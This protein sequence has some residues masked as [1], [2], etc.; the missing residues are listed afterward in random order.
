MMGVLQL[1]K[2]NYT[3]REDD[4]VTK[5]VRSSNSITDDGRS[6]IYCPEWRDKDTGYAGPF[7]AV[8]QQVCY[9]AYDDFNE[10]LDALLDQIGTPLFKVGDSLKVKPYTRYGKGGSVS[11]SD[12]M[13]YVE[14]K[15]DYKTAKEQYNSILFLYNKEE[16]EKILMFYAEPIN[17][18]FHE[19]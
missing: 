16:G 15:T 19:I 7:L 14:I 9:G 17:R 8:H 18:N 6:F 3:C 10:A 2:I 12:R 5:I 13:K 11:D 1:A 4:D